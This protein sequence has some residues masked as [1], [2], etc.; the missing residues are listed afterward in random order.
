MKTVTVRARGSLRDFLSRAARDQDVSLPYSPRQNAKDAFESAGIPH[1]EVDLMLVNGVSVTFAH[2][3]SPGDRV[4]VYPLGHS[5][6]QESLVRPAPYEPRFLVDEN[7]ARLAA[8]LRL[9]GFDATANP[10]WHDAELADRSARERRILLTRDIGLLKRSVVVHGYFLRSDMTREQLL[11]VIERYGLWPKR[12]PFTR[13][14]NCNGAL[15]AVAKESARSLVPDET[16]AIFEEFFRCED[17]GKIY[18]KGSH[19]ERM[20]SWMKEL[21]DRFSV[22]GPPPSALGS[23]QV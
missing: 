23:R 4:E 6:E 11:E 14:L 20:E 21:E 2:V 12:A 7:S 3:L 16:F 8:F 19:Y 17:C 10:A 9:L 13:C 18:W 1:V 22:H 5:S 15:A